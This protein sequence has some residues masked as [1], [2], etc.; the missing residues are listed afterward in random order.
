MQVLTY[1]KYLKD[2]LNQ[3]QPIPKINKLFI[4]KK[5]NTTIHDGLPDKKGDPDIPSISYLIGVQK[6]DQALYDIGASVSIIPKVIYDKINHN[7][8]GPTSMHLQLV[9]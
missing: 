6:L 3:R 2:I 4:A 5:C 7:S 9:D 1:A 8:F